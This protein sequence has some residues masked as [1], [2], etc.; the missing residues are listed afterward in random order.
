MRVWER[1]RRGPL[2]S[3]EAWPAS[4]SPA[5]AAAL[6]TPHP[7]GCSRPC[8]GIRFTKR[9]MKQ[10]G[11]WNAL[12][13]ARLAALPSRGAQVPPVSEMK[14]QAVGGEPG[15]RGPLSL[16]L[17]SP[18]SSALCEPPSFPASSLCPPLSVRLSSWLSLACFSLHCSPTVS[19]FCSFLP[20]TFSQSLFP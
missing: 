7:P 6:P 15:Q 4:A 2:L 12:F 10:S 18:G 5:P 16:T 17:P 11:T 20:I 1:E 9:K 19:P 3:P 8:S 13:S 14:V